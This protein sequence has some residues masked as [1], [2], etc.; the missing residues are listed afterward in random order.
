MDQLFFESEAKCFEEALP[1][2]NGRL[3]AMIYGGI[4]EELL[5]ANEDS[6]WYGSKRNRVNP[7]AKKQ[8]EEVRRLILEGNILK[9]QELMTYAFSGIPQSQRCYQPLCELKIKHTIKGT[10]IENYQRNLCLDNAVGTVSFSTESGNFRREYIASYPHQVISIRMTAEGEERLS[11]SLLITRGKFYDTVK[12]VSDDCLIMTGNL[13]QGGIKFAAAVKAVVTG[14]SCQIIGEHLIV[15]DAKQAE[16]FL[17]GESS[18]YHSE[19]TSSP[20]NS[21]TEACLKRV[22]EAGCLGFELIKNCHIEDYQRLY[23]SFS[24]ILGAEGN[25][26]GNLNSLP[27]DKRLEAVCQG[28]ADLGLEALYLNYSRYLLISGSRP[29]S[30]PAN[31]QGIWNSLMAPPW[32]SKFTINI[33]TEMNY[34]LADACG[35]GT[36][37]EPLFKHLKRMLKSGMETAG[38]MYG[39]RGFVAHHNTD[40]WADTAP[41]DIYIPA[42]YW[43][44]GGAWLATHIMKHYRYEE[45]KAWL[46]EMYPVLE[47]SVTFFEDF[48]IEDQGQKV[49]CPSVSPENTYL[50]KDGTRACACAGS[51]M[52]CQ[53]LRDL[54]KG[55]LEASEILGKDSRLQEDARKTLDMLPPIKTGSLGQI[56]EWR[57]EY[58]E[59]EPGH[60]HVSHLYG[61][62]PSNQI[63]RIKTPKLADGA[64]VTLKRRLE[65][66]GGYT[67]WSRAWMICLYARLWEGETAYN[68]FKK[69]LEQST[70]PNLMDNHPSKKGP[71]FQIDGNFG[72]MAGVLEM[73]FQQEENLLILLPALPSAWK[74]GTVKGLRFQGGSL[75]IWWDEGEIKRLEIFPSKDENLDILFKGKRTQIQVYKNVKYEYLN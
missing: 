58:E 30:L 75:N 56:L 69:L 45:N 14:G 61:L 15:T 20:Y 44:M 3:G 16:L 26:A 49:T 36:C 43:V 62:Y 55:F 31:L 28:S 73:L 40:I 10:A 22:S 19:N 37:Q 51:S 52:D 4:K 59:A 11:F 64:A 54:Y 9:A 1:I 25:Q 24:L 50:L 63:S 57:E 38:E 35:L 65:H 67:G 74:K 17:A 48:L 53:I 18:Y 29:G 60:R 21:E 5:S 47:Q 12:K 42:S 72:A 6:I 23:S 68:N 66:G 27:T 2:G 34:W 46:E 70:F 7:D 41:Q 39:C 32:D 71:V 33:N 13:G 8:L